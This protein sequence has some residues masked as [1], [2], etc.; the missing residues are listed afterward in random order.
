M[1]LIAKQTVHAAIYTVAGWMD[2]RAVCSPHLTPSFTPRRQSQVQ[3][4]SSH[5][6]AGSMGGDLYVWGRGESGQLGL[7]NRESKQIPV[8]NAGFPEGTEVSQV[9]VANTLTRSGGNLE[10]IN[11]E[12]TFVMQAGVANTIRHVFQVAHSGNR[13]AVQTCLCSKTCTEAELSPPTKAFR[14]S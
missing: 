8:L 5:C 7:G 2:F 14:R 6:L 11:A 4:G 13:R 3:A 9:R 10:Q 1:F 12:H